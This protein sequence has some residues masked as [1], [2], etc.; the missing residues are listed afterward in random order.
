[1][2]ARRIRREQRQYDQ[3]LSRRVNGA[4]KADERQRRTKRMLELIGKGQY[5]YTPAIM[6]WVSAELDKPARLITKDEVKALVKQR[7]AKESPR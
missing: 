1:M 3:A 5:P 6:S 4:L 7:S 2:G